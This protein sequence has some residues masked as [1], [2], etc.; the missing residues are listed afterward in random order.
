MRKHVGTAP[1]PKPN[2]L[3]GGATVPKLHPPNAVSCETG[4][5][6]FAQLFDRGARGGIQPASA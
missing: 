3:N 2:T 1:K 6:E 4:V 5:D